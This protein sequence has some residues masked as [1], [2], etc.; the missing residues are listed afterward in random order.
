VSLRTDFEVIIDLPIPDTQKLLLLTLLRYR[1]GF[2]GLCCPG[3]KLLCRTMR[4]GKTVVYE[5]LREL[6]RAGYATAE[7]AGGGP[8]RMT[9]YVLTLPQVNLAAGN[10]P[11]CAPANQQWLRPG[12]P[13][14]RRMGPANGPVFTPNGSGQ[15]ESQNNKVLNTF[16]TREH[17][18][19]P[20]RAM[21]G[22]NGKSKLDQAI[23]NIAKARAAR[24][25]L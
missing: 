5:A 12:E 20:G 17:R 6:E 15:P 10:A 8:G 1:N 24:R 18:F 4:K 14:G 7:V 21:G 13:S 16:N 9:S 2:T 3:V 19:P 22:A 11:E 23:A 25:G